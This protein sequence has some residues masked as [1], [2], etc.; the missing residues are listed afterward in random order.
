MQLVIQTLYQG[1]SHN[2]D[3]SCVHACA[4]LHVLSN[5]HLGGIG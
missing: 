2:G 5:L 3:E 1:H 4:N